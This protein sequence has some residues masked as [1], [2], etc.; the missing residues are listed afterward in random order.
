[1]NILPKLPELYV[2]FKDSIET[3]MT[4]Q[5]II[6]LAPIAAQVPS[7]N[8]KSLAIDQSM[9]YNVTLNNGAEVLWPERPKIAA[10]MNEMFTPPAASSGPRAPNP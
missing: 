4:L 3:D 8:I 1:M 6:A 9:T 5:Q 2:Q 10:L 7:D